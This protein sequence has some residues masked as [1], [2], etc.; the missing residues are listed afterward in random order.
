MRSKRCIHFVI[1]IFHIL[2][3]L[4]LL[5]F[6]AFLLSACSDAAGTG[7]SDDVMVKMPSWP[8]YNDAQFPPLD[9]YS[10]SL[11]N[12][13]GK[14][15]FNVASEGGILVEQDDGEVTAVIIQPVTRHNGEL[16]S[17]FRPAGCVL[18]AETHA[19][20]EGGFASYVCASLFASPMVEGT[21][22]SED[23][24][25]MLAKFNWQRFT[26]ETAR[27][28]IDAKSADGAGI[29][30]DPWT[31]K[32]DDIVSKI[33]VKDFTA[34]SLTPTTAAGNVAIEAVSALCQKASSSSALLPRYVCSYKSQCA[35]GKAR[36]VS[37]K[38][39][40]DNAIPNENAF[41]CGN[42]LVFFRTA[43]KGTGSTAQS[44]VDALAMPARSDVFARYGMGA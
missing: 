42:S 10:V 44:T 40:Q 38:Y 18:P 13:E 14:R 29:V 35:S 9:H 2:L 30:C 15:T 8:P 36:L 17:F 37:E 1:I 12:S 21:A 6:G 3:L 20:W 23:I 26:E 32:V 31:L 33:L 11:V 19:T 41:L 39:A 34:A 4:S 16:A 25:N 24:G 22:A 27:K 43:I 28:S 5:A 7:S